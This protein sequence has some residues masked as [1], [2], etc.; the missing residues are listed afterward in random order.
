M[1]PRL[2]V[3]STFYDL[4]YVREQLE[5]FIESYGFKPVLFETGGVGYRLNEEL[6]KSCYAEMASC[7]MA[8]VIIGGRYGS[9]ISNESPLSGEDDEFARYTSVTRMEFA[10]AIQKN[11]PVYVFIDASVNEQFKV[12]CANKDSIESKKIELHFPAIDNINVFRFIADIRSIPHIQVESFTRI[13]DIELY[14]KKQWA[15]LLQQHLSKSREIK[16]IKD[17]EFP[18]LDILSRIKRME[19]DL[20]GIKN[21]IVGR[22]SSGLDTIDKEKEIEETVSKFTSTFEFLMLSPTTERIKDYLSSFIDKFL[23]SGT[24]G[25]LDLPFSDN[26]EELQ[27][28]YSNFDFDDTQLTNVKTRL[29]FDKTFSPHLKQYKAEVMTKLLEPSN[30]KLMK[31]I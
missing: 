24:E 18:M 6:D 12:Y 1:E 9:P 31:F 29:S 22:K 17:V 15:S 30:L 23:E 27:T 16:A 5:C 3:S 8:I 4:K 10:T 7:D 2:F 13:H 11:I 20:N 25:F 19:I 28:F 21:S 26:T 14:L